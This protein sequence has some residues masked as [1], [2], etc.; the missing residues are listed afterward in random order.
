MQE[1]AAIMKEGGRDTP[2]SLVDDRLQNPCTLPGK[3]HCRCAF[4]DDLEIT[5]LSTPPHPMLHLDTKSQP[6]GSKPLS[7]KVLSC[8]LEVDSVKHDPACGSKADSCNEDCSEE[9]TGM[10]PSAETLRND[11]P[12]IGCK[13]NLELSR[14]EFEEVLAVLRDRN[15]GPPV[16]PGTRKPASPSRPGYNQLFSCSSKSEAVGVLTHDSNAVSATTSTVSKCSDKA[17]I[18]MGAI[19]RS[20]IGS[21]EKTTQSEVARSVLNENRIKCKH[22]NEEDDRIFKS[23]IRENLKFNCDSEIYLEP[24]KLSNP[25][26]KLENVCDYGS[27]IRKGQIKATLLSPSLNDHTTVDNQALYTNTQGSTQQTAS[28]I[29]SSKYHTPRSKLTDSCDSEMFNVPCNTSPNCNTNYA[30]SLDNHCDILHPSDTHLTNINK[31]KLNVSKEVKKK[32]PKSPLVMVPPPNASPDHVY[33]SKHAEDVAQDNWEVYTHDRS[34]P[35]ALDK[36][37]FR[38]SFDSAASM[39]FHSRTGLPLTSSPAP[40]RR[41][42]SRFDFDSSLNSVSAI[43]RCRQKGQMTAELICDRHSIVYNRRFGAL[44]KTLSMLCLVLL[45]NILDKKCS[46]SRRHDTP[47]ASSR[48]C[49]KMVSLRATWN[50]CPVERNSSTWQAR[51]SGKMADLSDDMSV[52]GGEKDAFNANYIKRKLNTETGREMFGK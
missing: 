3:H 42:T 49:R 33:S 31:D 16:H 11:A 39:V 14:Q 24:Q 45:K 10:K 25:P 40:V 12:G 34:I 20:S 29:S 7:G 37:K 1:A 13:F 44:F 8:Q 46:D 38:R 18:L 15:A 23:D 26:T 22:K 50:C 36:A 47:T 5:P 4:D 19:L 27:D 48:L 2:E 30:R 52:S 43:R 35:S 6:S 21:K 51:I 9:R 17:D 32:R 28:A 41:G